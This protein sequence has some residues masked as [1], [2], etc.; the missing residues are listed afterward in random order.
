[1]GYATSEPKSLRSYMSPDG[2]RF[3]VLNPKVFDH[4]YP[5]ETSL[6]F[7][8]DESALCLLRRDGDPNT[9]MLGFSRP[10]Y[11]GCEW[12][13]LGI[14]IGGPHMIKLPDNRL[15]A[16]VR[17]YEG[18]TRTS[19]C[20]VEPA[21]PSLTEFLVLPSGG[22]TSYAG[23]VYHDDLLW[24]SYYSTHEEKTAVYVAKVRLPS[25]Y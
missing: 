25:P 12:K 18:K 19:L 24:V 3:D 15:V 21:I 7:N 13:D 4:G 10:P 8:H 14:R 1:M 5:N 22:D 17:M 9:G 11:R 23:L 6:I 16:A 20:W 2:L